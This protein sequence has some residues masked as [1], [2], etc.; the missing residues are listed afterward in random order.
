MVLVSHLQ[1]RLGLD[2]QRLSGELHAAEHKL[3]L[4]TADLVAERDKVAVAQTLLERKVSD[5]WL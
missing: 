4:L 2:I 1:A 3:E 5:N